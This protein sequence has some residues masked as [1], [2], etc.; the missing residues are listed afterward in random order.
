[1]SNI[2]DKIINTIKDQNLL[3][4]PRWRFILQRIL[5]WVLAFLSAIFGS[6]AFSVMIFILVNNDWEVLKYIDRTPLQHA[7]ETLPYIWILIL[8]L[9][10]V[11]SYYNAK[12]TKGAYKHEG[13]W[14]LIGSIMISLIIGSVFYSFGLAPRIHTVAQNVPFFQGLLHDRDDIWMEGENGLLAGEIVGNLNG[15]EL[16]EL[17]DL[18]DKTWIVVRGDDYIAPPPGF[19]MEP[20]VIVR[21]VG[22]I[23]NDNIFDAN[24]IM[25]YH[26]G[27]GMFN[28]KFQNKNI[29]RPQPMPMRYQ[30]EINRFE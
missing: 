30:G 7:I 2:T 19:I 15:D 12:H 23:E 28:G 10:V 26:I 5:I 11:L 4:K 18:N 9:F 27:P 13:Y 25:P 6:L 24:I 17:V 16:F 3:P 20:G 8:I 14:F 1:M 21:M 22:E 29:N